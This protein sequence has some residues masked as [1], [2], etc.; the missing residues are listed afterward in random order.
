MPT[1]LTEKFIN[2][3]SIGFKLKTHNKPEFNI[4]T[5]P[6]PPRGGCYA[7]RTANV[8]NHLLLSQRVGGRL[9]DD[10]KQDNRE[11]VSVGHMNRRESI[12]Q[13]L[14]NPKTEIPTGKNLPNHKQI[15]ESALL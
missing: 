10:S 2:E 14:N 8:I 3:K 4:I 13:K 7:S 9:D 15:L 11:S 12:L 1:L 6:R 5:E